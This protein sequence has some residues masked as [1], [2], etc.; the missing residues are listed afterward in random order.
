MKKK[1]V[2]KAGDCISSI[3]FHYG[4]SN[5]KIWEYS[6]NAELKKLRKD[7]DVLLPGDEVYIP[8][9]EPGEYDIQTEKTHR[10]IRRSVPAKFSLRLLDEEERPRKNLQYRLEI[11]GKLKKGTTDAKGILNEFIPPDTKKGLLYVSDSDDD[12]DEKYELDFGGI[13]P[14]SEISG[15]KQRLEN[16]SFLRPGATQ[17]EF[18]T[19]V[20]EFKIAHCELKIDEDSDNDSDDDEEKYKAYIEIDKKMQD[21]LLELNGS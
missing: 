13:D 3:A 1:H 16:L 19:A 21:K 8:E 20:V 10:F 18:E 6:E 12:E 15:V 2:V 4:F 9:K 17:D 11:D 7:P 14:V 5:D